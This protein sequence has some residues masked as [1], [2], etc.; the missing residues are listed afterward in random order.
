[1]RIQPLKRAELP[2]FDAPCPSPHEP[3]P[4]GMLG[5]RAQSALKTELIS[6]SLMKEA[7]ADAHAY[8]SCATTEALVKP[9]EG[10]LVAVYGPVSLGP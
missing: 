3:K 2:P 9:I 7:D 6:V 5:L 8:R 1:M 10:A 4:C